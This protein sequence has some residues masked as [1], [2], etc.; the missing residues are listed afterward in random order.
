MTQASPPERTTSPSG[1]RWGGAALVGLALVAIL[2][3][4]FAGYVALNHN[5]VTV[6]QQQLVTNTQSLFSVQ[7]QTVTTANTITSVATVT[8]SQPSGSGYGNY[9]SCGYYG[10]YPSNGYYPGY[11]Y[12]Y[13]G[14]YYGY[15]NGYYNGY[16]RGYYVQSPAC[17]PTGN[18]GNVTCSGYLYQA[19]NGCTLLAVSTTSNP[20]PSYATGDVIEY[21]TLQHLP[22]S[23]PQAGSWITVNGQL[24]QG[25]NTASNGASCPTNYIVVSSIS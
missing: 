3:L 14:Y 25:Y 21:Y 20:Y 24:Y 2:S 15:N 22:S 13:P 18:Y 1:S 8:N 7:T 11:Y 9:Q 17:Q 6:T 5:A 4:G 19:S 10:C 23:T 16:Y 12:N